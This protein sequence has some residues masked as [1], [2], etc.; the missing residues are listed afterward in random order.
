SKQ[1]R[2]RVNEE[3]SAVGEPWLRKFLG[4]SFVIGAEARIRLATESKVRFKRR[5]RELTKP[6]K[7]RSFEQVIASVR[8]YLIG[9]H[10]YFKICRTPRMF[11]ELD[12]WIRHRLR[13]YL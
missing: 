5:I 3:K 12:E 7:G 13:C 6:T 2:L 8:R 9:W 1:L 4:F 10:G 11:R